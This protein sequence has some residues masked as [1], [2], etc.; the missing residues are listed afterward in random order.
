[1]TADLTKLRSLDFGI[2]PVNFWMRIHEAFELFSFLNFVCSWPSLLLLPLVEHFLFYVVTSVRIQFMYFGV[3]RS[4]LSGVD[5]LVTSP[6]TTPPVLVDVLRYANLHYSSSSI[7][8]P[9]NRPQRLIYLDFFVPIG[10]NQHQSFLTSLRFNFNLTMMYTH[11]YFHVSRCSAVRQVQINCGLHQ[12]LLPMVS[13]AVTAVAWIRFHLA[14]LT[15]LFFLFFLLFFS[16]IATIFINDGLNFLFLLFVLLNFFSLLICDF[17]YL[18]CRIV[19][20]RWSCIR[21]LQRRKTLFSSPF[22]LHLQSLCLVIFSCLFLLCSFR[23]F[24]SFFLSRFL[25]DELLLLLVLLEFVK[26]P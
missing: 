22:V 23:R 7:I 9:L 20:S 10:I 15:I 11:I 6:D 8:F 18:G 4:A 17:F 12:T 1:M 3:L 26:S 25:F 13:V 5:L 21:I 19:R 16:L 14:I 2:C 24:L